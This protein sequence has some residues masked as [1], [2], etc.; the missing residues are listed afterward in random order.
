MS[1]NEFQV[2]VNP[3]Q[4]FPIWPEINLVIDGTDV[5][6]STLVPDSVSI[7]GIGEESGLSFNSMRWALSNIFAIYD[8]SWEE[9]RDASLRCMK[10]MG[11]MSLLSDDILMQSEVIKVL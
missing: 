10:V 2:S 8:I 4:A 3:K 6:I 9:E 7:I 1:E 11:R 5:V